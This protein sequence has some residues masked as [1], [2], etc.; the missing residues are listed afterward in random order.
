MAR[1]SLTQAVGTHIDGSFVDVPQLSRAL[2]LERKIQIGSL[3]EFFEQLPP[4]TKRPRGDMS[5]LKNLTPASGRFRPNT[6]WD[7]LASMIAHTSQTK[8]PSRLFQKERTI[9]VR[10]PANVPVLIYRQ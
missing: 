9:V 10:R 8:R 4:A 7:T 5:H 3:G 2:Q 6:S 1:T